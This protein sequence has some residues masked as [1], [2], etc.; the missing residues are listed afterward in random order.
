MGQS[1]MIF[2]RRLLGSV[3]ER[4]TLRRAPRGDHGG[5]TGKRQSR[6]VHARTRLSIT[7]LTQ[8]RQEQSQKANW[9]TETLKGSENK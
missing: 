2:F 4:Y 5:K 9:T 7:F 1:A 6:S 8:W 3:T